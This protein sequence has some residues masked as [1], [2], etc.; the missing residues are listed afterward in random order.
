MSILRA[1]E[2]FHY[3][4]KDGYTLTVT[5]GDLFDSADPC[6]KGLEHLFESVEVAASAASARKAGSTA[7]SRAVHTETASAAPGERR[8]RSTAQKHSP[9]KAQAKPDENESDEKAEEK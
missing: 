4:G 3:P 5:G 7:A 8:S 6:V 1:K 2:T 9:A